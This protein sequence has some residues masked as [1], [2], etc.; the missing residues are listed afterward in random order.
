MVIVLISEISEAGNSIGRP[1]I[2]LAGLSP[3]ELLP[4]PENHGSHHPVISLGTRQ[5]EK[6][7][8]SIPN[9]EESNK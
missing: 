5:D 3:E 8:R 2:I 1:L 4:M 7:T 6:F 9:K